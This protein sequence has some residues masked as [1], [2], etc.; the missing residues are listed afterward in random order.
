M[1]VPRTASMLVAGLALAFST[2]VTTGHSA[3]AAPVCDVHWAPLDGRVG[4][5]FGEL[6]LRTGPFL[7]CPRN[8]LTQPG[9]RIRYDCWVV[10]DGGTWSHVTEL[11]TGRT[12]WVKDSLLI[13]NGANVHC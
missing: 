4:T 10:G 3:S 13:G 8:G 9:D 6:P 1:R 7:S 5:L 12:G 2:L 11:T